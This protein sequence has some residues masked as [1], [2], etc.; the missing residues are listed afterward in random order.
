MSKFSC[1]RLLGHAVLTNL[2]SSSSLFDDLGS[3]PARFFSLED[4]CDFLD[5]FLPVRFFSF[6][7]DFFEAFAD[8]PVRFFSP[9]FFDDLSRFTARLP[10][11][12]SLVDFLC[13]FLLDFP[14]TRGIYF[15]ILFFYI[16]RP[17]P[18]KNLCKYIYYI[19]IFI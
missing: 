5:D 8:F 14:T 13:D 15:Y 17:F 10:S 9:D 11:S 2:F 4:L 12:D 16:P 19:H 7:F 1:P 18:Q 6:D 3:L